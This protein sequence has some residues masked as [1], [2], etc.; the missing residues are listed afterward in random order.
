[1][2]G[3]GVEDEA[4]EVGRASA[5]IFGVLVGVAAG[6]AFEGADARR[7]GLGDRR[8]S[9]TD[10]RRLD[11]RADDGIPRRAAVRPR[12]AARA[13]PNAAPA[14]SLTSASGRRP[15]P[16]TRSGSRFL[17]QF[18]I[19]HPRPPPLAR[20]EHRQ[21][22]IASNDRAWFTA[23]AARRSGVPLVWQD[24]HHAG[25]PHQSLSR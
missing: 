25:S 19:S 2:P 4:R 18:S 1:M 23:C 20:D 11:G 10:V 14:R 12:H 21:T 17:R 3:E 16:R 6:G 9:V 8:E 22:H 24:R 15:N 13:A 5:V 7:A